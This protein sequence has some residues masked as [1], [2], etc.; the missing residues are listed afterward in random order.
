MWIRYTYGTNKGPVLD[1]IQIM[2][3][4]PVVETSHLQVLRVE[5]RTF[6]FVLEDVS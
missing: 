3:G 6:H 1:C 2:F 4:E 5:V